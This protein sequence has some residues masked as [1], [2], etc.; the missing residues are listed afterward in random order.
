MKHNHHKQRPA[1]NTYSKNARQKC[2]K[3]I[4]LFSSVH[5]VLFL[6]FM[7]SMIHLYVLHVCVYVYML[8]KDVKCVS[9]YGSQLKTLNTTIQK[10]ALERR[11]LRN[12][13]HIQK[14][15][16]CSKYY[17]HFYGALLI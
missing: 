6:H 14:P 10:S 15:I 1:Y 8:G 7:D 2:K 4:I 16:V 17:L 9:Y 13:P 12:F 5:F 11:T 3:Y